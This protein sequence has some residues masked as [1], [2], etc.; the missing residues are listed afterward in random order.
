MLP[1]PVLWLTE[2]RD[3]ACQVA[4]CCYPWDRPPPIQKPYRSDP[5]N[6]KN[7]IRFCG[8]VDRKSGLG[9]KARDGPVSVQPSRPDGS[10]ERVK[11]QERP[12]PLSDVASDSPG[13]ERTDTTRARLLTWNDDCRA[14]VELEDSSTPTTPRRQ[15]R[16][17]TWDETRA[18]KDLNFSEGSSNVD[19]KTQGKKRKSIRTTI[20]MRR[21]ETAETCLLDECPR[22]GTTWCEPEDKVEAISTFVKRVRQDA[23]VRD[24]EQ[25]IMDQERWSDLLT[26][27]RECVLDMKAKRGS[28]SENKIRQYMIN[29]DRY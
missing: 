21:D 2:M 17:S 1:F 13:E 25:R 27:M 14:P 18:L 29:S 11:D 24:M 22:L 9:E 12:S 4:E 7:Q 15:V 5:R 20:H 16:H 10:N 26:D 28:I 19:A 23:E 6:A 3:F 8:S